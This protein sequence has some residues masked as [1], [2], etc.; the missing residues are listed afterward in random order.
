MPFVVAIFIPMNFGSTAF[1][2]MATARAAL[3]KL[4]A[5]SAS[6]SRTHYMHQFVF[7]SQCDS[8]FDITQQKCGKK[9]CKKASAATPAE[10]EH[11][12]KDNND[13]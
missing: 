11:E 7:V 4:S 5:E 3:F 12:K 10:H 8:N 1:Y 9:Q 2:I 6:P 13:D